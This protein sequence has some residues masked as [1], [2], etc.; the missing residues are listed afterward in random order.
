MLRFVQVP[1]ADYHIPIKTVHDWF[2]TVVVTRKR[3]EISQ[4]LIDL[5]GADDKNVL[6]LPDIKFPTLNGLCSLTTHSFLRL[7]MTRLVY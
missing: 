4:L 2:D 1:I 6:P 3:E 5:I 7:Q